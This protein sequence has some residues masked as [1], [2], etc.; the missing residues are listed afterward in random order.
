M[1]GVV[2]CGDT[3]DDGVEV[4]ATNS[5]AAD[6]TRLVSGPDADLETLLPESA[7]P[8][9]YAASAKERAELEAADLVVA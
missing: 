5:I 7:S 4:V 9:D 3:D 1:A 8:H 6:I 2:G